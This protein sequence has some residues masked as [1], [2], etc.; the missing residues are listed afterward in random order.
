MI[1]KF[2]GVKFGAFLGTYLIVVFVINTYL[3]YQLYTVLDDIITSPTE[4]LFFGLRSVTLIVL[5]FV[6]FA[7]YL[8]SDTKSSILYLVMAL[9]FIF[10]EVL[11]YI[12]NY[13]IYDWSLVL[14]ERLLYSGGLV[15][16]FYYMVTKNKAKKRALKIRSYNFVFTKHREEHLKQ[17]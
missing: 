16:L 2:K 3:L 13:Y 6:S 15:F 7:V 12:R 8:N 9:C 17:E 5:A 11:F 1:T 10:S 14:V 4:V